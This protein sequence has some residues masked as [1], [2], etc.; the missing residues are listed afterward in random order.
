MNDIKRFG[1]VGADIDVKGLT[2]DLD[3]VGRRI[4]EVRVASGFSQSEFA[5]FLHIS[6]KWLSELENGK[7]CPSGLFLLGLECRFAISADWILDAKG[8]MLVCIEGDDRCAEAVSFL[9]SFNRLSKK[10]REKLLNILNAFIFIEDNN[11]LP[12]EFD[13]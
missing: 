12:R 1:I 3:G 6:R 13:I 11:E 10:G 5:E 7:K 2:Y 8:S 9:K 4:R